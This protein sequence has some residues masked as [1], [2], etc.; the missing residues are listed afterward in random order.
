MLSGQTRRRAV[1]PAYIWR[2]VVRRLIFDCIIG[3]APLPKLVVPTQTKSIR[4]VTQSA[5][6]R[7]SL[8][9]ALPTGPVNGS[10]ASHRRCSE[11]RTG[12]TAT[13]QNRRPPPPQVRTRSLSQPEGAWTCL[14]PSTLLRGYC[15]PI[16]STRSFQTLRV[17]GRTIFA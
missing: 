4:V 8:V 7:T 16:T 5:D 6:S 12:S 2:A 1:V 14:F 10:P 13:S 9:L 15:K 11:E 17:T 3:S